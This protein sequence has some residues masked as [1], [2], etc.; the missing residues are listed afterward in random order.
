MVVGTIQAISDGRCFLL[1]TSRLQRFSP[2]ASC[3]TD[4]RVLCTCGFPVLLQGLLP[5]LQGMSQTLEGLKTQLDSLASQVAHTYSQFHPALL[6]PG[7]SPLA[8]HCASSTVFVCHHVKRCGGFVGCGDIPLHLLI[9]T[10]PD[11]LLLPVRVLCRW[12]NCP[13]VT[14]TA[15]KSKRW[16]MLSS[17]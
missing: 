17:E 5:Q 11:W 6:I 2:I 16:M 9:G 13:T 14:T 4:V 15:G 12:Q 10:P 7:Q 1:F 8:M 3:H